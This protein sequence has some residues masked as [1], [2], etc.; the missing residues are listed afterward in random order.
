MILASAS[1]YFEAMFFSPLREASQNEVELH[2]LD[3]AA[4][5]HLL[6]FVYSG[7]VS[8]LCVFCL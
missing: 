8:Y 1:D 6:D 3:G 7:R 2:S 4:L 5:R